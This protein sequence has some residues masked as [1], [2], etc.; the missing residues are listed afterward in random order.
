MGLRRVVSCGSRNVVHPLV[1]T[2]VICAFNLRRR[3]RPSRAR[4]RV[5]KFGR[6]RL[7]LASPSMDDKPV[8]KVRTQVGGTDERICACA[9]DSY[10]PRDRSVCFS[11][12]YSVDAPIAS[13]QSCSIPISG[14]AGYRSEPLNNEGRASLLIPSSPIS[15][16]RY[17]GRTK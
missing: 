2:A 8:F 6:F 5:C 9:H 4:T 16:W 10:V 15:G 3:R 17:A 7:P 1:T 14:R 11:R 13:Q 12:R